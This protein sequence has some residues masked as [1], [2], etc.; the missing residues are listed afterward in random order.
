MQGS[1]KYS[2]EQTT[3]H[4]DRPKSLSAGLSLYD[5]HNTF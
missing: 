2:Y 1:N 4:A 3:K 5:K